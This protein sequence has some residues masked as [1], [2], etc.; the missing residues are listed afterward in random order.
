M[1]RKDVDR[2]LVVALQSD[3]KHLKTVELALDF[4]ESRTASPLYEMMLPFGAYAA[5]RLN[6]IRALNASTASAA[7]TP[8]LLREVHQFVPVFE[9]SCD[10]FIPRSRHDVQKLVAWTLVAGDENP[11][12]GGYG[13][14]VGHWGSWYPGDPF[15]SHC[16]VTSTATAAGVEA[17]KAHCQSLGAQTCGGFLWHVGVAGGPGGSASYCKPGKHTT[18]PPLLVVYQAPVCSYTSQNAFLLKPVQSA[19]LLVIT[20]SLAGLPER[21]GGTPEPPHTSS[22]GYLRVGY[23][24]T[25]TLVDCNFTTNPPVACD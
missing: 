25:P 5:A 9:F 12:R 23:T 3:P 8:Y 24:A 10:R 6:A 17:A 15:L 20:G 2:L 14:I 22:A 19:R 4:L 21:L 18:D 1:H 13:M 16:E 11:T 7:S